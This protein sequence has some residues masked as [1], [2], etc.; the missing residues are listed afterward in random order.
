MTNTNLLTHTQDAPMAELVEEMLE[1]ATRQGASSACATVGA[2]SGLSVSVR[3]G[4]LETVEHHRSKSLGITVYFGQRTGSASSTDLDPGALKDTVSAACRIARYTEEDDCAG[5]ADAELMAT[6]LL[7]LDLYHPWALEAEQATELALETESAAREVDERITNSDGASVSAYQGSHVYGNTHGF[8]G[9]Y[10]GTRHSL[11][12]TVIAEEGEEKQRDYW[13]GTSRRSDNL[14]SSQ[15]I[16]R[17][18]GERAV[19]RLGG[20]Q[21][22]TRNA[23]VIFPADQA[24][25]LFG[26]FIS[27]IRGSSLY[28]EA[29]FL[30]DHLGKRVF[31][32]SVHIREEPHIPTALGSSPFDG[33]GVATRARDLVR[34]GVLQGY[35]LDSYSARKLDMQTTGNAG[36]VHN[37]IVESGDQNLD[38]LLAD[39]DTGLLVTELI[40][41][42]VNI[43]TGDY[44]R[45]AAGFWVEGGEIQ[46]AVEEITIASNLMDMFN[47]IQAIGADVDTRSNIHTGSVL[48]DNM[49]IAGG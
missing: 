7:D 31:P 45:G 43:V 8:V 41:M 5:L 29:T 44:S 48:I 27:A 40:G 22:S 9:G 13:Y 39:M 46:Y 14:P 26:S 18:A 12:C 32:E 30:L 23:P 33:E 21:L 49:T 17:R 38:Q 25:R 15:E 2:G 11:S 3:M 1:E 36:G 37:L 16:G 19:R 24:I 6:E 28:R 42:G 34:D 47:G 10:A 35:V 20:R 4:A